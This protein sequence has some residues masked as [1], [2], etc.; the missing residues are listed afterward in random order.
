[1]Q[2]HW[3][4]A[5]PYYRCRFPAE[6][7]L[8][9]KISHP[10]NV[11]L[12][13]DAF[14]AQ[15]NTWLAAAF[16]PARLSDT[17]DQIVAGQQAHADRAAAQAAMAKIEDASVKMARYRAALDADG[18]PEEIGKTDVRVLGGLQFGAEACA[19]IAAEHGLPGVESLD[20]EQIPGPAQAFDVA[21]VHDPVPFRLAQGKDLC[22]A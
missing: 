9:S 16:A 21:E 15:V 5:A 6:Y 17:I 12:R 19:G 14:D 2:G 13:Q 22:L 1:M 11:Y 10:R 8:A 20:R 4:N 18:D 3:I 7:A